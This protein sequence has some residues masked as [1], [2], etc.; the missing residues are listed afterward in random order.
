MLLDKSIKELATLLRIKAISTKDLAE[1]SY[2]NIVKR[3]PQLNSFITIRDKKDVLHDAEQ[4]EIVEKNASLLYGIPFSIKD[5]YITKNIRTT[6]GNVILDDFIPPYNATVYQKVTD[7]GAIIM[8]KN[9]L[10]AWGHGGS[11]ENTSYKAGHNPWDLARVPGGSSGGSAAAIAARLVSFAIGEDTGGS[12][13]N[14]AGICG[15][16]GLKVTYGRV[17]RYGTIAYASSLDSVGPMAKSVEDLAII[18]SAIAGKDQKDATSSH[19]PVEEYAKNLAKSL[20]GK[21]I[22]IPK[23]FFGKGLDSE[24]KDILLAAA[25]KFEE[26][27][28]EI[29]DVSIP[30]LQYGVSIY[31]L[32]AMSET[33]SNLAKFDGIRYG[34][35]RE[36]FSPETIRRVMIGTYALSSGYADKLYKKAQKART[37]LIEEFN[38]AFAKCDVLLSPIIPGKI[39]KIGEL[40]SDP[41]QN[42]LE[43]LYTVPVNLVG[44]PSLAIP[45]G[46]TSDNLPIGMQLIGKKFAEEEL[47]QFGYNYQQITSWHERKPNL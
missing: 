8:G 7:A 34:H 1:E 15:I 22:G 28:V 46:F 14:P 20:T 25:K 11:T 24:C 32:I 3:N 33:S 37:V 26:I 29:V 47:L 44:V 35:E 5:A 38:D 40:I 2:E 42:L 23:E 21:K 39:R 41:L 19:R 9:N 16:S 43:D 30:F 27:G 13:R 36:L 31:Y 45:A 6:A 18:L 17:S 10:D 12:I 4:K